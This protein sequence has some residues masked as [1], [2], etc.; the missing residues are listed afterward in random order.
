MHLACAKHP[1]LWLP[2]WDITFVNG[3]AEVPDDVGAEILAASPLVTRE[4]LAASPEDPRPTEDTPDPAPAPSPEALGSR[5][6][7]RR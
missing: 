4:G 3:V 6:R 2:R 1:S 5:P 7:R